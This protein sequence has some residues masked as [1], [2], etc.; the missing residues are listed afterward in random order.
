M[1]SEINVPSPQSHFKVMKKGTLP[2]DLVISNHSKK[3]EC[4]AIVVSATSK[5]ILGI[6]SSDPST[7]MIKFNYPDEF[8]TLSQI[9]DFCYGFD[10]IINLHNCDITYLIS[11][12]LAIP[13][14]QEP[15]KECLEK[16]FN[17]TTVIPSLIFIYQAKGIIEPHL[18]FIK[19]HFAEMMYHENLIALPFP[20]LDEILASDELGVDNEDTLALW[21][22]KVIMERGEACAKLVERLY[23]A[24]LSDKSLLELCSRE[25]VDSHILLD[26]ARKEKQK[27]GANL[28]K[29]RY[30]SPNQNVESLIKADNQITVNLPEEKSVHGII[31]YIIS[32]QATGISEIRVEVSSTH[33]K[34]FLPRN[35][36]NLH[37][38]HSTWYSNDQPDQWVMYD[39]SP[40]LLKVDAYTIRTSGGNKGQGHLKSWRVTASN[41]GRKWTQ[42]DERRGV[43]ELNSNYASMSFRC[44]CPDYFRLIKITQIDLNHHDDHSFILSC[45]EFFGQIV[46]KDIK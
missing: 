5:K 37:D 7:K 41:D 32:H 38:E 9:I 46:P 13:E 6:M 36:L 1:I 28:P 11:T 34:Y 31:D 33:F 17:L 39:F 12:D 19:H 8:D 3:Y 4:H 24:D 26:N 43:V 44:K 27:S 30:L 10:F 29:R 35:L 22:S 16:S 45:C 18:I 2:Y 40:R 20:I 15:A 42:L 21:V 23:L 14:L 25:E